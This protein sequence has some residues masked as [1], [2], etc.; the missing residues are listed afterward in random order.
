MG[1]VP[2]ASTVSESGSGWWLWPLTSR[3]H[4][5]WQTRLRPGKAHAWS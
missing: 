2:F 3:N 1:A 5:G 4:S